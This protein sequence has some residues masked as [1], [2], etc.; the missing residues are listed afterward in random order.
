MTGNTG[1]R[2]GPAILEAPSL[3]WSVPVSEEFYDFS[4]N[5]FSVYVTE[6]KSKGT[7]ELTVY[8]RLNGTELWNLP[9]GSDYLTPSILRD[10][11]LVTDKNGTLF[12]LA[13]PNDHW[14]AELVPIWEASIHSRL[15]PVLSS[16]NSLFQ[17]TGN[18]VG[19]P[20]EVTALDRASGDL[21]WQT[22]FPKINGEPQY[23][24][25]GVFAVGGGGV[26]VET[27]YGQILGMS[28]AT[29]NVVGRSKP[30]QGFLYTGHQSPIL[31]CLLSP[32]IPWSHMT[33]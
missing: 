10:Q 2:P 30:I 11:L 5:E 18:L 22:D 9:L 29:G 4:V 14:S 15:G 16:G 6:S 1:S 17:L 21:L 28:S 26:Y 23:S 33:I 13:L 7:R 32:T 25:T 31:Q 27:D 3:I 24:L 19:G 12:S 20:N 8:D